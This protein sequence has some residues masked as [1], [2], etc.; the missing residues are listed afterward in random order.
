MVQITDR[1][2][3]LLTSLVAIA[4]LQTVADR[5]LSANL[6]EGI[7]LQVANT[8]EA[9]TCLYWGLPPPDSSLCHLLPKH[10]GFLHIKFHL[11]AKAQW[12]RANIQVQKL[13]PTSY[14][15]Y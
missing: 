9:V 8:A 13:G 15:C 6:S 12:I 5:S 3:I 11:P 14:S 2:D 1:R 10:Q 4:F 7:M